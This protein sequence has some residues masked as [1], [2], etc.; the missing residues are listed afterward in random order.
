MRGGSRAQCTFK[1]PHF[2][3][4]GSRGE[5][6]DARASILGANLASAVPPLGSAR[7][8]GAQAA[9]ASGDFHFLTLISAKNTTISSKTPRP[10]AAAAPDAVATMIA[11]R[12]LLLWAALAALAAACLPTAAAGRSPLQVQGQLL[13]QAA[14][15]LSAWQQS[16]L[17][18]QWRQQQ[19]G[20]LA[21]LRQSLGNAATGTLAPHSFDELIANRTALM[22]SAAAAALAA[23][24]QQRRAAAASGGASGSRHLLQATPSAAPAPVRPM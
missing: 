17:W 3:L 7:R 2:L 1:T 6:P 19:Q 5:A 23:A 14:P 12:R 21:Q 24:Q 15:Q 16:P 9:R 10:D 13:P 18:Q 8:N 4:T 22:R 11:A 20:Q